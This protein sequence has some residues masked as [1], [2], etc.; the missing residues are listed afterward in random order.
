MSYAKVQRRQSG[1]KTKTIT[2]LPASF[3]SGRQ[4]E[5]KVYFPHGARITKIR[6]L[7]TEALSGTDSGTIT[8][9][10]S[11]GDSNNGAITL[12]ASSAF[13]TEGDA[14]PDSNNTVSPDSY[15]RVTTDKTT[16]GGNTQVSLEYHVE[17]V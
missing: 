8:G 11:T 15:Y 9:G 1:T 5:Y 13:G 6:A 4:G 3:D 12:S 10:N 7:V 16:T 17:N 2:V 14:S